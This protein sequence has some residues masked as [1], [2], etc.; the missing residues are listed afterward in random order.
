MGLIKKGIVG[1]WL[2]GEEAPRCEVEFRDFMRLCFSVAR[3]VN[4]EVVGSSEESTASNYHF[5]QIRGRGVEFNLLC[6][7]Y[8]P[9][10][11]VCELF[12]E[13]PFGRS[14]TFIGNEEIERSIQNYGGFEVLSA[15]ELEQDILQEEID[16]LSD[17]EK[18][19]LKYWRATK[20]G[21]IIFNYFD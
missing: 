6:N 1:F 8:Y 16:A 5:C 17:A 14:P 9:Y 10:V 2:S 19:Q 3:D 12:N 18:S 11:A 20:I 7:A 15:T 13:R 4:G 21:E